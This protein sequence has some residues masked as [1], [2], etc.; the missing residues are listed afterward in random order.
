MPRWPETGPSGPT[1]RCGVRPEVPEQRHRAGRQGFVPPDAVSAI[2]AST[3]PRSPPARHSDARSSRRVRV[4]RATE[5]RGGAGPSLQQLERRRREAHLALEAFELR[6]R[7]R[8]EL[9]AP[10]ELGVQSGVLADGVERLT[11]A[12]P[13]GIVEAGHRHVGMAVGRGPG[14]GGAPLPRREWVTWNMAALR[15]GDLEAR[16]G[17][18]RGTGAVA[19]ARAPTRR[20]PGGGRRG[21]SGRTR[22]S[23]SAGGNGAS[24]AMATVA[25]P[26]YGWAAVAC[27]VDRNRADRGPVSSR[28]QAGC[29]YPVR[30]GA[31]TTAAITSAGWVTVRSATAGGGWVAGT[32]TG[33]TSHTRS[34][35]PPPE[36]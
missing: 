33:T 4:R 10:Q 12:D 25:S 11:V 27:R 3:Y 30:L 32:V 9:L 29:R 13:F 6:G 36:N 23:D 28:Y 21:L 2:E 8:Q 35:E 5:M 14:A 18:S 20:G 19:R 31:T 26:G 7:R 24:P 34:T 15:L 1:V 17:N 22:R 16:T